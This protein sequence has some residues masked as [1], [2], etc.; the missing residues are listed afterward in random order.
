MDATFEDNGDVVKNMEML[1]NTVYKKT[2]FQ[3]IKI[4]SEIISHN[5]TQFAE[6]MKLDGIKTQDILDSLNLE[7]NRNM[8]FK[9][10]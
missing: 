10:G 8:V 7:S 1:E 2:E 9:A 3:R 4:K 5:E 6:I